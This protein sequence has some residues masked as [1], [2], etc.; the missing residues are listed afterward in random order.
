MKKINFRIMTSLVI[1]AMMSLALGVGA[2][3]WFSDTETST[4]NTFTAG[5][6]DL[7][8]DGGDSNVVKFTVTNFQPPN[9][10][11]ATYTLTNIGTVNGYLDLENIVV[12]DYE[13]GINDPEAEA[14]DVTPSVGELSSLIACTM[15]IDYGGDGWY[16]TGDVKFYDAMTS[17][18]PGNFELDEPLN[19]GA[20]TY[21]TV[22]FNWW[23]TSSDN[24]AQSD[25]MVVDIEFELG[26]QTSQ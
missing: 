10:P 26:Q 3:A 15:F 18:L 5:T 13:N 20:T 14:G 22:I 8:V 16:S 1:I 2:T 21:I 19:A 4:G 17:G 23:S 6:L 12:T 11:K 7:Q 24:L 9:Q 25:S